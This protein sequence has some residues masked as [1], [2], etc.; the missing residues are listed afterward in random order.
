MAKTPLDRIA[1]LG[2][3]VLDKAAQ[4]ATAHKQVQGAMQLRERVD[5][6]SKRVRGLE[7]MENR[8]DKLEKRL[9]KLEGTTKKPSGAAKKTS[10]AAKKSTDEKTTDES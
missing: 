3:E 5:D 4:N 7:H 9:A 1:S 10:T 8:I 2:E 6:L